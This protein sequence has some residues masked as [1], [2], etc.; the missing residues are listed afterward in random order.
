MAVDVKDLK[1]FLNAQRP[2]AGAS[3][4][5]SIG[6]S[7]LNG[8]VIIAQAFV[9]AAFVNAL[10]F[11]AAAFAEVLP[12]L[13]GLLPLFLL[14][15]VLAWAAERFAIRAA[16][17]VKRD[18]RRRLVDHLIALGPMPLSDRPV[19]GI[20]TAVLDGLSK[21]ELYYS[22]Y[23]PAM[24]LAA[25]V[26]FAM[27]VAVV[28]SDWLSG[29]V[30]LVTAPLIPLFMMLIGAGAERVNRRQWRKLTHMGGHFLD[31][32]EGLTTLKL[33]SASRR[34][35]AHVAETAEAYRRETMVVLRIAFLSALALEFFA[36]VSIAL[37]AVLIG[38]RL[39][40]GEMAFFNGFFVLLLAP[41]FYLP[42]RTLGTA[43][44]SRMEAIGASEKVFELLSAPLPASSRGDRRDIGAGI[45]IRFENVSVAYADG[46]T[47]LDGLSFSIAAG[48]RV[49]LIG[50]S[51]AGKS[52]IV[53]L[54]LGFIAPSA[55]R[56]LVN[57][58]PLDELDPP[59]WLHRIAYLPQRPHMFDATI[60][61]NIAMR[62]PEAI[63]MEK[64]GAAARLAVADAF[65]A[66]LPRGYDTSVGENGIGLS[67]GQVQRIA[68]A[69]AFHAEAGLVL[70]DEAGAH[71]DTASEAA[72]AEALDRLQVGRTMLTIAHRRVT[73]DNADR[74]IA[75]AAGRL[76]AEGPPETMLGRLG[77]DV[78]AVLADGE[79]AS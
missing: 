36:T 51:G 46:R 47:G 71:L 26:P 55:G 11:E 29:I 28:P 50:P 22:R 44:H 49:A 72:I 2:I 35:A 58:V 38:F 59:A 21:I 61:E 31:V 57:D 4:R 52:T 40:W 24:M 48:E 53:N 33:M 25:L 27:F 68:L 14:R 70:L 63:D 17:G 43:Y 73:L 65:I 37:V 20:V 34:E 56:I 15:A 78:D 8:L 75:I 60:A 9:V 23:L 12:W 18:L 10:A 16:A 3:L 54:L 67:G 19:G 45:A 13:F 77:A 30:L 41:E 6:L 76:V 62:R 39:L 32:V 42:L 5:L 69:R 74:V 66:D 79:G 64:V 1:A 7:F